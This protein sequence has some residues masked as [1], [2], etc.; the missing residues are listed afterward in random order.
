MRTRSLHRPALYALPAV[1]AASIPAQQTFRFARENVLGTS[2]TLSVATD[3][4][5][6]AERVE[7]VVLDEIERLARVLSRWDTDSELSRFAASSGPTELSGDLLAVL[8]ACET[9]R[10]ASGGAFEPG[11]ALLT[12][13]WQDASGREPSAEAIAAAVARLAGPQWK[14]DP[15]VRTGTRLG[16]VPFDVDGLA[17]G[18]ILDRACERALADVD[19]ARGI[20]LEIGG[21]VRAVGDGDWTIGITDPRHPADNDHPLCRIVLHGGAIATSGGYA[22]GFDIKG[23]H[24]SHIIDPRTGRPAHAVIGD[25]V[26]AADA[27]TADALATILNVLS[28]T[29]GLALIARTPGTE[30]VIVT[31]DGDVLRSEGFDAHLTAAGISSAGATSSAWPEHGALIVEFELATPTQ[32]GRRRGGGKRPYVAVWIEDPDGHPCRTLCL[33]IESERWLR[34]L[35]RWSRLHGNQ[36]DLVDAVSRA[37]RRPG[38]YSLTWDGLDDAGHALP[39]GDY[40]VLIEAVREHGTYQLMRQAVTI[41]GRAFERVLAGNVEVAGARVRFAVNAES[42]R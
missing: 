10:R 33:W 38:A 34:D 17:K 3:D 37:T 27:T 35:R 11:I 4:R 24:L 18:Y 1:L 25:S 42:S 23:E 30:G 8:G 15:E 32:G 5:A 14:I 21:D 31:H 26:I 2:L 13:L 29:D 19:G 16:D 9:W 39:P 22:R 36:R 12:R 28:P 20:L 6:T 7:T 40:V 41:D